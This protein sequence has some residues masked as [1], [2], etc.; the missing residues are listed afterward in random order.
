[1]KLITFIAEENEG[2]NLMVFKN[3]I[4]E[5]IKEILEKSA[6][7]EQEEENKTVVERDVGSKRA[8]IRQKAMRSKGK[9]QKYE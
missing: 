4:L 6:Q 3:N 7:P 8:S 1:M 9:S 5:N 2:T